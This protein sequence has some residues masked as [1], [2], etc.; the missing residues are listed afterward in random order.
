M[1]VQPGGVGEG[2]KPRLR[3]G[4]PLGRFEGA[5]LL[6]LQHL[7]VGPR[8][9]W[10]VEPVG[11][12]AVLAVALLKHTRSPAPEERP[13]SQD[14]GDVESAAKGPGGFAKRRARKLA[15]RKSNGTLRRLPYRGRQ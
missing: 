3:S 8:A 15:Y 11:L 5:N 1:V 9:V 10:A 6:L 7:L 12:L 4:Y 14:L 13:A 2:G